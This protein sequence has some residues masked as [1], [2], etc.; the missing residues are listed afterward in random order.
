MIHHDSDYFHDI[1]NALNEHNQKVFIL[2]FKYGLNLLKYSSPGNVLF[3]S[4]LFLYS[5]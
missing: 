2:S 4:P 3:L 5:I 1:Y